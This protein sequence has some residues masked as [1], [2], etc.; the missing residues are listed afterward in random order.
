MSISDITTDRID[1]EAVVE[2][3]NDATSA[4]PDLVSDLA[5]TTGA[6]AITGVRLLTR[7]TKRVVRAARRNPRL[8]L[9]GLAALALVVAA[10]MYWRRTDDEA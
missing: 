3:L 7:N 5:A 1:L 8:T 10:V 2:S 9:S 4:A 6:A